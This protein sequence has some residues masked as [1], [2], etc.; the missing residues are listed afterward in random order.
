[1]RDNESAE[2]ARKICFFFQTMGTNHFLQTVQQSRQKKIHKKLQ[3][4][5]DCERAHLDAQKP[6]PTIDIVIIH[7]YAIETNR[8]SMT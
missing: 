2:L 4:Q 1:M 7:D 8:S 3:T 6:W 5:P